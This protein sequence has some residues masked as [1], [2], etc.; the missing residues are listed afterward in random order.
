[1]G[2]GASKEREMMTLEGKWA[3]VTG[4]GR[5]IGR[6]CALA[7]AREGADLILN[8]RPG[9][10]DL[11]ATLATVRARGGQAHGFEADVFSRKGCAA[12]V[13]E[14]LSVTGRIDILVSNPAY[15]KRAPF[16]E[17]S[18]EEFDRVVDA[19]FKAGFHLSQL[20]ARHMVERGGGGK[21]IFISSV[22]GELPNA[23]NLPYGAAK[24]A[25]NHMTKTIAVE[26]AAHRIN[27]NA[28]APGWIDTP[29]ERE[30]FSPEDFARII[31]G[32]PWGRIGQPEE[33]GRVAAFL[34]AE[35]ADYITGAIIP[36]DGAIRY[37]GCGPD[38]AVPTDPDGA[39]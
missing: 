36:V 21:I 9:S 18:P 14:A 11:A 38:Q 26:L 33:I 39:G 20:V 17:F 22:Q 23:H 27:V 25:L 2:A 4:A 28:I 35:D 19:T 1:M 16:L 37:R 10:P 6:A 8:D 13:A 12:L 3:L 7:L 24:A 31:P 5:G 32:L 15:S 34:A 30:T 29:N